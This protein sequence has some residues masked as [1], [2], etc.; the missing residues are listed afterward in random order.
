[1]YSKYERQKDLRHYGVR[2]TVFS[3]PQFIAAPERVKP[4]RTVEWNEAG[5]PIYNCPSAEK[6]E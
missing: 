6:E 3:G 2:R 5:Q 1:M 4:T